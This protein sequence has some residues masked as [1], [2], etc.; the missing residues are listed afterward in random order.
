MTGRETLACAAEILEALRSQWQGR[1]AHLARQDRLFG[2]QARHACAHVA[3]YRSSWRRA[4]VDPASLQSVKDLARLPMVH[5]RQIQEQPEAFLADAGDRRRWHCSKTSGSTGQ[6]LITW[7]DAAC[8]RRVKY[9]LKL[10]RLLAS[11]WHPGLRL[12]IFEAIAPEALAAHARTYRLP[13]ERWAPWRRYFSVF[14]PPERHLESL[15]AWRPH[16]LYG[17]PSHFA[18]LARSWDAALRRRVPLRALMTSG[19]WMHPNRR[20]QLEQ[21]FG[22]RVLDVYGSTEFKEIAWQCVEGRGY[23]VSM[24]S[25]IVEIVDEAGR[26]VP[27][28]EAGEVAVTSLTNR[29]MPLIR[30]A[31][32]D[33]ARR[34]PG[35]CPCGRGL[36]RLEGVEGRLA[37]YLQTPDRG[38]LS[39]YELT[40]IL[41]EHPEVLQYK[42]VQRAV[43]ALHIVVVLRRSD[44]EDGGV[45]ARIQRTVSARVGAR[46]AV[47]VVAAAAVPQEPSGKRRPV[48]IAS[49]ARVSP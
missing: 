18:A 10:R 27:P 4:G 32:G 43:D 12:A 13:G 20:A 16:Y 5:R 21:N 6:P 28:G 44:N 2:A 40:T 15:A 47:D 41:E 46:I 25:V 19:E 9:A 3:F 33:R 48:E 45:L 39:P 8:W 7:F 37:D 36:E 1:E 38:V 31:T 23:H 49:S 11:G 22:V 17:F 24:D 42:V 26:E 29:A 34:L 30:Y 14:E 35:R